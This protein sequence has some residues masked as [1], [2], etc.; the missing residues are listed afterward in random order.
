MASEEEFKIAQEER[1]KDSNL[2][3]LFE[4]YIANSLRAAK[5]ELEREIFTGRQEEELKELQ[6]Q[7]PKETNEEED[8][9]AH[10]SV[11]MRCG[12]CMVFVKK[13][14]LITGLGRC[15]RNAPTLGGWPA[16]FESDWCGAHKLDENAI[17]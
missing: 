6:N 14:G 16:V 4:K 15:R 8:N 3:E 10:R 11:S 1:L 17:I 7:F 12:S 2:F 13:K 5:K 9:W